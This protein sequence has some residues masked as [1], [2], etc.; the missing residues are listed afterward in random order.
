MEKPQ[1]SEKEMKK[2][3]LNCI[4]DF[5]CMLIR[6]TRWE[7]ICTKFTFFFKTFLQKFKKII[8]YTKF[9]NLQYPSSNCNLSAFWNYKWLEK[10]A[11][12]PINL[13]LVRCIRSGR[14]L[15]DFLN[16]LDFWHIF[17]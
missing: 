9:L 8:F 6:V 11:Y 5:I 7:G 10:G 15:E 3:N 4:F 1:K 13:C 2:E 12:V 14:T 16:F 17:F